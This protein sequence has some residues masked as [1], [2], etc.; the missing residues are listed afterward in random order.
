MNKPGIKRKVLLVLVGVL[1][2][3]T[4]LDALLAS[5]FTNQQNQ[6]TAFV[7]LNR[8]LR[9]WHDDLQSTTRRLLGA[10]LST[11]GDTNVLNQLD[12]LIVLEALNTD[13][14][15]WPALDAVTLARGLSYAKSVSLNRLYLALRTSG[16]S[17]IAVYTDGKLSHAVSASEAGMMRQREN[18]DRI[19][20][21]T[22]AAPS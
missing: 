11:A 18:G 6:D 20:V 7:A 19:W 15:S 10:A 22:Q 2:L 4:A 3:T 16:F 5:Y 8:S 13:A 14:K 17:R 12:E 1:S 21:V 9:A